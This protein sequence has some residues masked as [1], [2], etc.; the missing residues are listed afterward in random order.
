MRCLIVGWGLLLFSTLLVFLAPTH[1][2]TTLCKAIWILSIFVVL[3]TFVY[4]VGYSI[5]RVR[6]LLGTSRRNREV[7]APATVAPESTSRQ[8]GWVTRH[9]WQLI[10]IAFALIGAIQLLSDV[11]LSMGE[12]SREAFNRAQAS[13]A[14]VQRLGTPI[15]RGWVVSGTWSVSKVSGNANIALPISG[16]KAKGTLYVV[17]KKDL[18]LWTFQTLQLAL[19]GDNN[20]VD[21]LPR[22]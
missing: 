16:P 3:G 18:G 1:L 6:H 21:L 17:A 5:N 20:R 8:R 12:V 2:A 22:N 10:A 13:S 11:Y 9:R 15:S 14:A 4:A 19:D 7:G